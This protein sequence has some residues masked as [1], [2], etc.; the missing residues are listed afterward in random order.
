[1]Q[2]NKFSIVMYRGSVYIGDDSGGLYRWK[3][4]A[5]IICPACMAAT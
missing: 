2:R 1:M 4:V 5:I 3:A